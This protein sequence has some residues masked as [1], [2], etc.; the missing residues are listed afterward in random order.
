MVTIYLAFVDLREG[1]GVCVYVSEK[2][3]ANVTDIPLTGA[4]ALMVHM[5]HNLIRKII[6]LPRVLTERLRV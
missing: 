1:G 5:S 4:E 6:E 3:E 2:L